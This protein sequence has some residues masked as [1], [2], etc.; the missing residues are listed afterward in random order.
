MITHTHIQQNTY[1]SNQSQLFNVVS[2][3]DA[4]HDALA[5]KVHW[6]ASRINWPH[7]ARLSDNFDACHRSLFFS[8]TK[9]ETTSER[10]A[11]R[12]RTAGSVA[13]SG[14]DG[15]VYETERTQLRAAPVSAICCRA[16]TVGLLSRAE[17]APR[18]APAAVQ[19]D[20][21]ASVRAHSAG[22]G[23]FP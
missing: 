16:H 17:R 4:T 21:V 12:S 23:R 8:P 9:K 2:A 3:P 5:V 11:G 10:R 19:K 6:V 13:E 22:A 20:R 1:R 18:P 14:S 15:F 7:L